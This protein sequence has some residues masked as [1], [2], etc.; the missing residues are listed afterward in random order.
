MDVQDMG[1]EGMD[2]NKLAQDRN[3]WRVLVNA[4]LNLWVPKKM[5]RIS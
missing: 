5:W 3:M 1:R 2:W 4:E